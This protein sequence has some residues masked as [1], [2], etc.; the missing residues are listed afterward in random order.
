MRSLWAPALLALTAACAP[1]APPPRLH[2]LPDF[3]MTAVLPKGTRP[4]GRKDLKGRAWVVDFVFTTCGTICPALTERFSRLAAALPPGVGLL[5]ITVDPAGDTPER[6]REY[7]LAHG[8]DG[9]RWVFLRGSIED[10]YQ[11]LFAGFRV[12]I[13]TRP[14]E[15]PERRVQHTSRIVLL[16]GDAVVRG[17]YDGFSDRET[18]ALERA[19]RRISEVTP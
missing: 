8:I 14:E 10:T 12:P 19:A 1:S 11:L 2:E 16:D 13:S 7:M 18:A 17:Y 9:E 5:S 15:P 3:S 6:L 4:F